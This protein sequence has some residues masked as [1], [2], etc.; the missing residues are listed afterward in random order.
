[1][2]IGAN[3]AALAPQV[4]ASVPQD[5]VALALESSGIRDTVFVTAALSPRVLF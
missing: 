3:A 2:F 4:S 1:L 5:S